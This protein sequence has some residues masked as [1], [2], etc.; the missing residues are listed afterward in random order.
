[1]P[2]GDPW[3]ASAKEAI[4]VKMMVPES[5]KEQFESIMQVKLATGSCPTGKWTTS[6]EEQRVNS[7]SRNLD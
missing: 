4:H 2:I 7:K 1:M 3:M 6:K 5:G